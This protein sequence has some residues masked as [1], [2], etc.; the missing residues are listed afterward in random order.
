MPLRNSALVCAALVIRSPQH[1]HHRLLQLPPAASPKRAS[2]P[3]IAADRAAAPQLRAI[4]RERS[5]PPIRWP[6]IGSPRSR[7]CACWRSRSSRH[8]PG[9]RP[10]TLR[11]HLRKHSH[12]TSQV[13]LCFLRS[14]ITSSYGSSPAHHSL[15]RFRKSFLSTC[16]RHVH[17]IVHSQ[18]RTQRI[19]LTLQFLEFPEQPLNARRKR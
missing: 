9:T 6:S 14:L 15:S 8:T 17:I 7:S 19:N 16:K 18:R 5:W 12:P 13:F 1:H 4:D 3:R 2:L 10:P 11:L